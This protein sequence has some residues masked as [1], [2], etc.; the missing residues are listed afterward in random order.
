MIETA[1]WDIEAIIQE[2]TGIKVSPLHTDIS[3]VTGEKVVTNNDFVSAASSKPVVARPAKYLG[4]R[5]H[6]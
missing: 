3:T 1:H 2:T 5:G 6:Q 4:A